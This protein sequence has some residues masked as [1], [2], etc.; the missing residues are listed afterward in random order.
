MG[1]IRFQK[2]NKPRDHQKTPPPHP[3]KH[4]EWLVVFCVL[5]FLLGS[6]LIFRAKPPLMVGI[7]T[8]VKSDEQARELLTTIPKLADQGVN[9]MII[10]VDYGFDWVTHPELSEKGA[11][12]AKMARRIA[13]TCRAYGIRV[14]PSINCLGHQSWASYTDRL[15]TVYPEFDESPGQYPDNEGIYCRSWCPQ[16]PDV[17]P[18]I[19]DLMGELIDAFQA[20]AFH[21]GM[22]EVFIIGSPHCQ[23]C[24]GKSPAVLYAKAVNDYHDFLVGQKQVEMLMW[25]DRLLD[26]S[27][28]MLKYGQ[29]EASENWTHYAINNI[30]KDIIICDWHYRT[31]KQYGSVP[32]LLS[33]G[34]RVW[35]AS[36]RDTDAMTAQINDSLTYQ[37]EPRMLGHLFTHW[38]ATDNKKLAEW[39]TLLVG[40][41]LLE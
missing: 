20:D 19:F 14:I 1:L 15:L 25:G 5:L 12:S 10:Q 32:Y 36:F 33:K 11:L 17:N 35:P 3:V 16:H 7:H 37:S 34:F 4:I 28:P 6:A 26:A 21:V 31:R 41:D 27:L 23:R 29:F 24:S 39:P 18:I 40:I 9:T 13:H 22:D 8:F 30:P 2:Q 38:G